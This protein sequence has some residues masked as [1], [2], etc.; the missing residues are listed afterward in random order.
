MLCGSDHFS[1]VVISSYNIHQV[2]FDEYCD[3]IEVFYSEVAL[4]CAYGRQDVCPTKIFLD[5]DFN[6]NF[7]LSVIILFM[8]MNFRP[9]CESH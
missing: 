8:R 2:Q 6:K 1:I 7:L 4:S 5:N 3:I 9:L